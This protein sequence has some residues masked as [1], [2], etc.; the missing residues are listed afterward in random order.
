M[1]LPALKIP[2]KSSLAASTA[3]S[4][5]EAIFAGSFL[6]GG[7]IIEVKL[8]QQLGVSRPTVREAMT[9]LE[10]E[11][12]VQRRPGQQPI[13]TP[14]TEH[15]LA[16]IFQ[17]RTALE[18]VAIRLALPRLTEDDFAELAQNIETMETT[19]DYIEIAKLDA[20][21]HELLVRASG[22]ERLLSMWLG[23]RSQVTLLIARINQGFE[24]F[25]RSAGRNHRR[26]LELLKAGDE[27]GAVAEL[28]RQSK[29]RRVES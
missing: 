20:A 2:Q 8:A 15:D 10:R 16:E 11:G 6:P 18:T 27:T 28:E 3:D 13:V 14:L 9:I 4:L 22:S 17:I 19:T 25:A 7:R 5:R 26:L 1:S 29:L 12:L 21:F 23:L 24:P